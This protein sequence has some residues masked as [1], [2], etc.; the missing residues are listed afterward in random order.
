MADDA[1]PSSVYLNPPNIPATLAYQADLAP[2]PPTGQFTLGDAAFMAMRLIGI[3]V[4]ILSFRWFVDLATLPPHSPHGGTSLF[5]TYGILG[6]VYFAIGLFL[7]INAMA[8][9]RWLVP[10]TA[11]MVTQEQSPPPA[12]FQ[13]IAFSIIGV[14]M[15]IWSVPSVFSITYVLLGGGSRRAIQTDFSTRFQSAAPSLIRFA[16]EAALGMW[17]FF[18]SKRLAAWW[19][20]LRRSEFIERDEPDPQ[21]PIS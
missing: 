1:P 19:W 6:A 14:L 10:R 11:V 5:F 7:I 16:V 8:L 13:A 21:T 18:G 4:L 15:V 2:A 9:A 12:Q 17:L 20:S 3:Y